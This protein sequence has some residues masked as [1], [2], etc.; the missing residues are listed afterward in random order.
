MT[1]AQ[2]DWAERSRGEG[3]DLDR[4]AER[5]RQQRYAVVVYLWQ[6]SGHD[7]QSWLEDAYT[8]AGMPWV[9]A[10]SARCGGLENPMTL[11]G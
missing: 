6:K 11:R 9:K 4:F 3:D 1:G 7:V 2:V 5:T 10:A 8:N